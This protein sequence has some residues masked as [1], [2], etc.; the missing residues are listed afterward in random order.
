[1]LFSTKTLPSPTSV[2]VPPNNAQFN[3]LNQIKVVKHGD[4]SNLSDLLPSLEMGDLLEYYTEGR[5]SLHNLIEYLLKITGSAN[6]LIATW[7]MTEAPLRSLARMKNE[8]LIKRLECLLEHKVPGHNSRAY[9]YAKNIFDEI[10]LGKCH[11]KVAIIENDDWGIV[12]TT[13]ANLT[14]NRRIESGDIKCSMSSATFNR[15]WIEN[16][17]KDG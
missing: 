9:A 13:S 10:W 8:G 17:K 6:V 14:R 15:A 4:D 2:V 16:Q 11:A 1:M 3:N 12:I 7:A 5:F